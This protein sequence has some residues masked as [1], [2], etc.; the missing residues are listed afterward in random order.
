MKGVLTTY[1][2]K[3]K[4]YG[5]YIL[6]KNTNTIH[7][8][9]IKRNLNE[10]IESQL[11]DIDTVPDY[12]KLSLKEFENRILEILHTSCFLSF[13]ALKSK[14]I[15]IDEVLSDMGVV[16]EIAHYISLK[17]NKKSLSRLRDLVKDLQ[18]KAVGLYPV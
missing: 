11:M 10:F 5:S 18:T 12:S 6:G 16:H 7:K 8:R 13:V 2:V 1:Y 17:G 14:T 3:N 15:T 4:P 9:L